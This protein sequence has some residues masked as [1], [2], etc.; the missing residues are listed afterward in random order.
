[1]DVAGALPGLARPREPP[2]QALVTAGLG[3][4]R[5][6]LGAGPRRGAGVVT[7]RREAAVRGPEG[8][9]GGGARRRRDADGEGLEDRHD[10]KQ[11]A[12]VLDGSAEWM[13]RTDHGR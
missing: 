2:R 7:G 1:M 12:R 5:V 10:R 8:V 4:Q 13:R 9:E 6:E 3:Q 11:L